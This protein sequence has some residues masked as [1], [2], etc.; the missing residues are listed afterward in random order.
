MAEEQLAASVWP[1]TEQQTSGGAHLWGSVSGGVVA[2][3]ARDWVAI[4]KLNVYL[5]G[6]SEESR[7]EQLAQMAPD[8][9]LWNIP[10]RVRSFVGRERQ[11]RAIREHLLKRSRSVLL[12]EALHG[13][14]G[15]GKTQLAL[16]YADK[17]RNE[18]MLGWWVPSETESSTLASLARLSIHLG[19]NPALDPRDLAANLSVQLAA[20]ETWLLI[21]DNAASAPD[22]TPFLPGGVDG[23]LLITSRSHAWAGIAHSV[24]VG[25]L[26]LAKAARLLRIRSGDADIAASKKLAQELGGLP[27]ALDQAGGYAN[28][29]GIRLEEYLEQFAAHPAELLDRGNPQSYPDT[30][31]RTLGVALGRL[32]GRN[33]AAVQLLELCALMA[34]EDLPIDLIFGSRHVLP[35]P[36]A[37]AV[38]NRLGQNECISTLLTSG[39]LSMP[40]EGRYWTHRLV[41]T[42]TRER[43]R[44]ESLLAM[45]DHAAKIL[46]S[47]L[48][49]AEGI[50]DRN[51]VWHRYVDHAKALIARC[52][53][54]DHITDDI[55]ML[56]LGTGDYLLRHRYGAESA[57]LLFRWVVDSAPRWVQGDDTHLA[58]A[59]SGLGRALQVKGD[60]SGGLELAEDALNARRRLYSE[61]HL[62]IAA[63]LSEVATCE[64]WLGRD[65]VAR[66]LHQEALDMRRRLLTGDHADIASS[67]TM[68]GASY[69]GLLDYQTA[70][71]LVEEG[72]SM[73]RRLGLQRDPEIA[74]SLCDLAANLYWLGET[75]A[76]R[77]AA[78]EALDID[79][80]LFK[81]D[82]PDV[83]WCLRILADS[84]FAVGELEN[85][86]KTYEL[87]TAMAG[88]L[89]GGDHLDLAWSLAGVA[90]VMCASDELERS[91]EL[92]AESAAMGERLYGRDHLVRAYCLAG[93]AGVWARRGERRRAAELK[94]E[95][96]EMLARLSP[97][98]L[99]PVA[100]RLDALAS[101][102]G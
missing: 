87:A 52:R 2:Q 42:V 65:D 58:A 94:R 4:Q 32:A 47:V 72:L 30:V 98:H 27:L 50:A 16:A 62:D 21:F 19:S 1:P 41:Q 46:R 6:K 59:L 35:E 25:S 33:L 88:R 57:E 93:L 81:S 85:A 69:Y 64:Y 77:E 86:A 60:H 100:A 13:L 63:S 12:P 45:L 8:P 26:P 66:I 76:A 43:L 56:T 73:R 71:G 22:I 11:I 44:S 83:L 79:L 28:E 49:S 80:H 97:G 14:G 20:Y 74:E 10:P 78:A 84:T 24:E 82:H 68:L 39:M 89:Y 61:D 96:D 48:P 70:R 17:Y 67:L 40:F 51:S 92:Y 18:Y 101:F 36:L 55:L 53:E 90:S 9:T 95:A 99:A 37:E 38:V 7:S 91:E 54:A 5:G 34:P 102:A 15:V 3:A 23:H 31:G 29:C 75:A